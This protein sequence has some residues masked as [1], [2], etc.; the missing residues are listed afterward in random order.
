MLNFHLK[1]NKQHTTFKSY[2]PKMPIHSCLTVRGSPGT[3][4]YSR[5]HLICT[6]PCT[7]KLCKLSK[8]ANYQSL[9]YITFLSM[10][11]TCVQ[12]NH[13]ELSGACNIS[14]GHIYLGYT[15]YTYA[16]YE[17]SKSNQCWEERQI[18]KKIGP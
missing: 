10:I 15:L 3:D 8:H 2:W 16:N 13:G 14:K 18:K 17:S 5:A 1:K 12:D 4:V 11:K 6:A 7:E 9:F